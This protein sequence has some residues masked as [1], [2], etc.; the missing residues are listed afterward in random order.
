MNNHITSRDYELIS[1]YLDNHLGGKERALFEARL[2]SDSELRKELQ[3]ISKTR[4]IV[5]SLSK[6]HAPR[7]YFVNAEVARVRPTLR[8]APVFGIVSAVA[9]VLLALVIFGNRFF[10]ASSQV[11]MAPNPNAPLADQQEV[12]R[13]VTSPVTTTEVAP[14]VLMGAPVLATPTPNNG[15]F[16]ISQTEVATPTTIYLYA[17]PPTSTLEAGISKMDAETQAARST[18]EEYYGGGANPT[19][20]DLNN[21]P[22]RTGTPPGFLENILPTS[23]PTPSESP[24]PTPTTPAPAASP[25]PTPTETPP[26]VGKLAPLVTEALSTEVTTPDQLLGAGNPAPTTQEP[27]E[28]AVAPNVFFLNYIV[29]SVEISLAVIAIIAGITA[30]ILRLRAR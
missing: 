17:Y 11:A 8:L 22:T 15:S 16:A 2:K 9:S 19:A 23:T 5:R 13:N 6:I 28:T 4:L 30:I 29:L 26:S 1:S 25:T 10:S 24:T 27:A 14:V 18:C 7:N 3:E 12:G 21:C 20:S